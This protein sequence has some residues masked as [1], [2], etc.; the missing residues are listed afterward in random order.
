M[1]KNNGNSVYLILVMCDHSTNDETD[2]F[3]IHL[4]KTGHSALNGQLDAF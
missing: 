1:H 2:V 4:D 3:N